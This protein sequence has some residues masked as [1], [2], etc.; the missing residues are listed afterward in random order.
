MPLVRPGGLLINKD[1][2]KTQV[3][4]DSPFVY[5]RM[6]EAGGTILTDSSVNGRNGT[7][8]NTPSLSQANGIPNDP[9]STAVKFNGTTQYATTSLDLTGTGHIAVEFWTLSAFNTGDGVT[10]EFGAT[11]TGVSGGFV[12]DLNSSNTPNTSCFIGMGSNLNSP[13][14]WS[15]TFPKPTAS[16]WHHFVF[17]LTLNGASSATITYVDGVVQTLTTSTHDALIND[18][19]FANTTLN[20][21]CRNGG[22]PGSLFCADTLD[23]FAIYSGGLSAARVKEHYS[24]A[25]RRDSGLIIPRAVQRSSS[26]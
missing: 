1:V 13:R 18:T 25:I 24:A 15:D 17:D 22:G 21:M 11:Y 9:P 16:V 7:Y 5:Y 4:A 10:C 26:W 19:T 8:F 23:E 6:D 20:I 3:L 14:P 2:Y 12:V